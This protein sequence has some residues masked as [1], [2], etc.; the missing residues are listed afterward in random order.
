VQITRDASVVLAK[1]PSRVLSEQSAT[2]AMKRGLQNHG[3]H[4]I[5]LNV[6]IIND[7]KLP[8]AIKAEKRKLL[9]SLKETYQH[10]IFGRVN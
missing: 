5:T 9:T 8:G 2:T 1:I 3:K 10:D 6:A 7:T 4:L